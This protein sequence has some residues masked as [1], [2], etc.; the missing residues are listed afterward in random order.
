MDVYDHK[1]LI[2]HYDSWETAHDQFEWDIPERYNIATDLVSSHGDRRGRLA[3]VF[4]DQDGGV[5]KYTF[6]DLDVRSNQIA[7]L[8][9]DLGVTRGDRVAVSL[10]NVPETVLLHFAV[11]KLGAVI[12]PL[13]KLFGTD[14][15]AYRLRDSG[16]TVL[17]TNDAGLEKVED[18]AELP[19]LETLVSLKAD[20]RS[21][22]NLRERYPTYSR[23]FETVE[24]HR[25]DDALLI[26][27]S[28]TTGDP[29]GVL[30]SHQYVAGYYPGFEMWND[31][32]VG[33]DQ[34]YWSPGDWAWVGS[35]VAHLYCAWHFGKPYVTRL[36]GGGFDPKWAFETIERHG[37][38]NAFI[39]PTALKMMMGLGDEIEQY[40]IDD[41][42]NISTGGEPCGAEVVRWV[43]DELDATLV[44]LFGQ[45][46]ANMLVANAPSWFDIKPGSMGKP[47]PGRTIELIDDDGEPV[48]VGEMGEIALRQ[49]D[50]VI[51]KRYWNKPEKTEEAFVGD[52]MCTGDMAEKDDD[53]YFWYQSR[54]DDVIITAG[55]RVGPAEVEETL[56]EYPDVENAAVV[57]EED[58]ERGEIIKAFVK[59]AGE[60]EPSDDLRNDITQFVKDRLA[61]Y[62]YPREIEFVESFPTT[63]TGKVQ[64]R[65]L[66]EE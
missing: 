29:K 23:S 56:V 25:D 43:E 5:E 41:L 59:L 47:V 55:Y 27:T 17:V 54:K 35:L 63:T 36:K 37:I 52:W 8:L 4:E 16:S 13:S 46:E 7:N 28:G 30:H 33:D 49:P 12:V 64:R 45:T 57:G 31:L 20:E 38:T 40:D 65:K 11:Y 32:D 44:D 50:P 19:A 51:F 58:A 48:D 14:A 6:Y 10:P 42:D 15:M 1:P 22:V 9:A 53:G 26:Y 62:E 3:L 18:I 61:K 2:S 21:D 60:T 34:L 39:P 24:T 66:R